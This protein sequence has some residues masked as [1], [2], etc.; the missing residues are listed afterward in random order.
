MSVFF[1]IAAGVCVA[2]MAGYAVCAWREERRE[3]RRLRRSEFAHECTPEVEQ[4]LRQAIRERLRAGGL[5][6]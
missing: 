1:C 6:K 2:V 5:V 4:K 3:L